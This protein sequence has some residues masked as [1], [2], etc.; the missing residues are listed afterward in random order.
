VQEREAEGTLPLRQILDCSTGDRHTAV[1]DTKSILT[2]Q[3]YRSQ[4]T[5]AVK[6][7]LPAALAQLQCMCVHN[8]QTGQCSGD[9]S[10]LQAV[11][12]ESRSRDSSL[13]H[14]IECPLF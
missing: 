9:T 14:H 10:S 2:V 4:F 11:L 13:Q 7:A 12:S 8:T 5:L 6:Q 3:S 1:A